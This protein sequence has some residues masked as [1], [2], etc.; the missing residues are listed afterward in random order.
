MK[1]GRNVKVILSLAALLVAVELFNVGTNNSLLQFG[2]V[3][4]KFEGLVGV[5]ISPFVHASVMHLFGNL[6]PFIVLSWLVA[7]QGIEHYFKVAAMVSVVGGLLVWVFGRDAYHV[8]ASGL[9]FG[10]WTFLIARAWY[11]RSFQNL[12]LAT[13]A[14]LGYSGLVLG[15]LPSSG[16]SFESHIAGAFAGIATA[17]LKRSKSVA[18][19]AA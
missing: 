10:L 13:V 11:Q 19:I 3:P 7:I 5:L 15:F 4:R 16:T 1:A 17:W 6:L 9:I 8:G 2:I 18:P 14:F 12:I